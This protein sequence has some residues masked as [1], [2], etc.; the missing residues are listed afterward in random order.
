VLRIFGG[1]GEAEVE[2]EAADVEANGVAH[3]AR[4]EDGDDV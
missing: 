1:G 4:R 3:V 2:G